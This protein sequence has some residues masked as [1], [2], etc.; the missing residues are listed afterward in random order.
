MQLHGLYA[1]FLKTFSR[2][3]HC[4]ASGLTSAVKLTLQLALHLC[5]VYWN[6]YDKPA[7]K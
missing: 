6:K 3:K 5:E 2:G 1:S 4:I 7:F